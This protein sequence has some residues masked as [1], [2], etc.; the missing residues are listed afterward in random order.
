MLRSEHCSNLN[1]KSEDFII[2]FESPDTVGARA[3]TG[4]GQNYQ[5]NK[6]ENPFSLQDDEYKL[7]AH[8]LWNSKEL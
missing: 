8:F 4:R 6:T 3:T 1:K 5:I 2:P 7:H